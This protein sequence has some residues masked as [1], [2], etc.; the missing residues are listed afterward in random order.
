MMI[1]VTNRSL[2]SERDERNYL[3]NLNDTPHS[4]GATVKFITTIPMVLILTL[5]LHPYR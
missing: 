5:I 4:V 2:Y 3:I 1:K